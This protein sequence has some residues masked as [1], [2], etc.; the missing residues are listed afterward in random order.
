MALHNAA[1]AAQADKALA[2]KVY[3]E[4][5]EHIQEASRDHELAKQLESKGDIALQGGI[6]ST[7]TPARVRVICCAINSHITGTMG[8]AAALCAPAGKVMATSLNVLSI[9]IISLLI[10]LAGLQGC[11]YA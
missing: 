7:V 11:A 9:M 2:Q 8:Y 3:S 10:K 6:N 1:L 5:A 4:Q